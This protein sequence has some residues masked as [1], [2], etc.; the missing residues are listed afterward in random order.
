MTAMVGSVAL[1]QFHCK[2]SPRVQHT[3]ILQVLE[4]VLVFIPSTGEV[5]VADIVRRGVEMMDDIHRPS[6]RL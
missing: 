5:G 6:F 4:S 1:I 3:V 2:R